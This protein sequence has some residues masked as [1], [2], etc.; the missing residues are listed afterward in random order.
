[1]PGEAVIVVITYQAQPGKGDVAKQEL[2]ALIAD[3]L[4]K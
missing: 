3:V 2:S 1:M 4:A